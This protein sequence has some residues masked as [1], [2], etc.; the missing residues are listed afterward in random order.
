MMCAGLVAVCFA[1]LGPGASS[2]SQSPLLEMEHTVASADS[3]S[4]DTGD[5][6]DEANANEQ[7]EEPA[8]GAP[9]AHQST[10]HRTDPAPQV[11]RPARTQSS[12][13]LTV[14]LPDPRGVSSVAV[15]CPSGFTSRSAYRNAA[16]VITGVPAESCTLWFRGSSPYKFVGASGGQTLTCNFRS[17][18]V[19]CERS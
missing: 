14:T 13:T 2:A 6:G 17:G 8:D 5:W 3:M 10:T 11:N 9:H 1:V 18:L 12:G 4:D 15:T 16:H 7:S 19:M